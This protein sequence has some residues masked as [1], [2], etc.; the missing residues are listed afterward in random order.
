[1]LAHCTQLQGPRRETPEAIWFSLGIWECG[2]DEPWFFTGGWVNWG[3]VEWVPHP[4]P[5]TTRGIPIDR[6]PPGLTCC[7]CCS[8][9]SASPRCSSTLASSP[10]KVCTCSPRELLCL[11]A[12]DNACLAASSRSWRT[13]A[14]GAKPDCEPAQKAS[15]WV[16]NLTGP[17][18]CQSCPR[19]CAEGDSH[20]YPKLHIGPILAGFFS[21]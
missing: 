3:E 8:W 9:P 1:M 21:H 16:K 19:T 15:L 17:A 10:R 5:R 2:P 14:D 12:S 6:G 7:S 4:M 11:R 18:C 13:E 20:P